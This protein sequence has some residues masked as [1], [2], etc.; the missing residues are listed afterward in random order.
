MLPDDAVTGQGKG[1]PLDDSVVDKPGAWHIS[2]AQS[3]RTSSI[4]RL[5]NPKELELF[6]QKI[7]RDDSWQQFQSEET[8]PNSPDRSRRHSTFDEEPQQA[9]PTKPVGFW[10]TSLARTR[11][12]V[13]FS[14]FKT[15]VLLEIT[16]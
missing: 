6:R 2:T 16:I 8:L 9:S 13:F 5:S 12:D 7:N 14:Y 10:S 1:R 11:L 4:L 3:T 15:C